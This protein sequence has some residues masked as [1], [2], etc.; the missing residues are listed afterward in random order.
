MGIARSVG[1]LTYSTATGLV[2]T[3]LGFLLLA[4]PQRRTLTWFE[5]LT[6]GFL[7]DAIANTAQDA[8]STM[9]KDGFA[10]EVHTTGPQVV[11]A[12]SAHLGRDKRVT[13]VELA[14]GGGIAPAMWAKELRGRGHDVSVLL[15]D[16]QPNP[17]AWER[18][19][20][21]HG[22]HV[23][24]INAPV[25]ATNLARTVSDQ[26]GGL[27]SI[28]LALHHFPSQ[29]VHDVLAD[30][31]QTNS[32]LLVADLA[33]SR[34]G[35]LYNWVLALKYASTEFAAVSAVLQNRWYG[36]LLGLW[37]PFLTW[38]DATVSVL[39]AY[40]AEDLEKIVTQIPGSEAYRIQIF[41]SKGYGKWLGLP[42]W[43]QS[44]AGLGDPVIQ[45]FWLAPTVTGTK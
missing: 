33:P 15:T 42:E 34:G 39:R 29:L 11:D 26:A 10:R 28:H 37:L 45:Y 38:H 20:Q 12:M 2:A 5:F 32:G 6:D 14:A 30:V 27:R 31:I 25:D 8:L 9:W 41:H 1:M 23:E 19:R 3:A 7:P 16:L 13:M 18:I 21:S 40:S 24:Y 4:Y 36:P 43:M 44:V 22:E 35:L 17:A